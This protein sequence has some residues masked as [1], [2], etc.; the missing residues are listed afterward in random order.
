[1]DEEIEILDNGL[2]TP[3]EADDSFVPD[4]TVEEFPEEDNATLLGEGEDGSEL[5]LSELEGDSGEAE[6][7]GVIFD[8]PIPDEDVGEELLLDEGIESDLNNQ[9]SEEDGTDSQDQSLDNEL[10]GSEFLQETL[11]TSDSAVQQNYSGEVLEGPPNGQ[12]GWVIVEPTPPL[13]YSKGSKVSLLSYRERR[14]D[15]SI[16]GSLGYSWFLPTNYEPTVGAFAEYADLYG[17]NPKG[18][19][20]EV[21][22]TMKRNY[23][24]GSIGL[25]AGAGVFSVESRVNGVDSTLDINMYRLGLTIILDTLFKEPWVAPYIAGGGY[26]IQKKEAIDSTSD[27]ESTQVAPYYAFGFLFQLDWIDSKTALGAFSEIGLENTY[28][29]AEGRQLI[30][31]SAE[32]DSDFSTDIFATAGFRVEL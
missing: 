9:I 28:L 30:A 1:M 19:L 15:W 17:D 21:Q 7:D 22:F 14:T 10:Q 4:D 31:S 5:G 26:V 13:V 11:P 32:A 18:P 29:F 24:F 12:G 27:N 23:G 2:D 6:G 20:L 16:M 25:D 8:E 3:S